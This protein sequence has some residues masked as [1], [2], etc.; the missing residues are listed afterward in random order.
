MESASVTAPTRQDGKL[1][2]SP[3]PTNVASE[4]RVSRY[5]PFLTHIRYLKAVPYTPEAAPSAEISNAVA[6]FRS[7]PSGFASFAFVTSSV[8]SGAAKVRPGSVPSQTGVMFPRPPAKI[9]FFTRLNAVAASLKATY[10]GV[11]EFIGIPSRRAIR[12]RR[13]SRIAADRP[14][15][16]SVS[17][18]TK[19]LLPSNVNPRRRT[20]HPPISAQTSSTITTFVS[21][22]LKRPGNPT[23]WKTTDCLS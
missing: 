19:S 3:T 15:S 4:H 9:A 14:F 20:E 7:R 17:V 18:T 13:K 23:G 16:M 12:P 6:V 22:R 8:L 1:T 5:V 2:A 10:D 11:E 21:T